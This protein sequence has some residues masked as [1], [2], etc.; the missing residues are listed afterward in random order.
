MEL[1]AHLAT[2]QKMLSGLWKNATGAYVV[3]SHLVFFCA[4]AVK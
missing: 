4:T 1:T 2:F 3:K